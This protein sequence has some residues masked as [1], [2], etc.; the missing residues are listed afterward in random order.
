MNGG[1]LADSE[2]KAPKLRQISHRA[3]RQGHGLDRLGMAA[4]HVRRGPQE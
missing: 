4:V 1:I 3:D 2:F